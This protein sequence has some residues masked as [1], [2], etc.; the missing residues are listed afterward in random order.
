MTT[1]H[2]AASLAFPFD[3]VK[4]KTVRVIVSLDGYS[5]RKARGLNVPPK[6]QS[7]AMKD[8]IIKRDGNSVGT[9][10]VAEKALNVCN[11]NEKT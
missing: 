9:W 7:N 6:Q 4:N 5:R 11:E 3:L 1:S 8:T 2:K 10:F